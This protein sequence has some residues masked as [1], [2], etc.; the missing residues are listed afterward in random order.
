MSFFTEMSSEDPL[1]RPTVSEALERVRQL[2][3]SLSSQTLAS[4]VP[5][6]QAT[7]VETPAGL[8]RPGP[9][10]GSGDQRGYTSEMKR[11]LPGG[12]FYGLE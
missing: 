8:D 10:I 9:T 11:S 6:P 1:H 2:K 7:H 12:P 4:R 3:R 5:R